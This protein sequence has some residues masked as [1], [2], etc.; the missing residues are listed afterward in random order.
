MNLDENFHRCK[1]APVENTNSESL[2]SKLSLVERGKNQASRRAVIP[3]DILI[4][5][6]CFGLRR[7]VTLFGAISETPHITNAPL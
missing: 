7:P 5:L 2:L 4:P 1:D 3:I 6:G